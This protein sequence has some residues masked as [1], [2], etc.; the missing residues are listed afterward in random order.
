MPDPRII[1]I[2]LDEAT[3]LWRNADIEQER[4]IAM[5]DQIE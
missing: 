3:I 1:H 5:F 4:R 2:E